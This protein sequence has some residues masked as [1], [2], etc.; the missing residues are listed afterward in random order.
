LSAR[1]L[2]ARLHRLLLIIAVALPQHVLAL[3]LLLVPTVHG[4]ELG[5]TASKLAHSVGSVQ[6]RHLG[7]ASLGEAA[8]VACEICCFLEFH[9]QVGL[10]GRL[11][12]VEL[13]VHRFV[14]LNLAH[15]AATHLHSLQL[16]HRLGASRVEVRVIVL[17][18]LSPVLLG[19][20]LT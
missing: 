13:R 19:D 7:G 16:I 3:A 11:Q 6:V 10:A 12:G 14:A 5:L 4:V 8:E 15:V 1:R 17:G 9:L 2:A 18:F 20:G